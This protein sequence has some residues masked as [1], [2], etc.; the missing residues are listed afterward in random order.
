MQN[1][2]TIQIQANK[3]TMKNGYCPEICNMNSRVR[4]S[5]RC[6]HLLLKRV[7]PEHTQLNNNIIQ[8]DVFATLTAQTG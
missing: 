5:Y 6:L 4:E 1:I 3:N 2:Y 7:A 8:C